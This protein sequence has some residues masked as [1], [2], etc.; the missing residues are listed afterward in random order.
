MVALLAGFDVRRKSKGRACSRNEQ[1]FGAGIGEGEGERKG[2]NGK[3]R[4]RE[5]GGGS[6]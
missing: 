5:E 6:G 3:R 1:G 4:G 2:R